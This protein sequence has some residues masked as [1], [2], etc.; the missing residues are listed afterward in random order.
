MMESPVATPREIALVS[1]RKLR[2]SKRNPRTHSKKQIRQIA[3]SIRRF[4]WT[5]PILTDENRMILAG[6]G[7]YEAARQLGLRE[8][9]VM[10]A[11]GLSDAEKRAL[12]LADNK[13]A[14]NAGWN[15]ALL[16]AEL[17]ELADLLPECDLDLEITGFEAA[18]IDVLMGDLVDPEHDPV[19]ELPD[20][21]KFPVSR[22]GDLWLLNNHRLRCGD[23]RQD[24]DIRTVLGRERAAMVFTDPPYNQK[25]SSIQGRGRIKHAE[26]I[27]AS[28]EMSTEQYTRF[29]VDALSLAAKHSL[30]GSIH[31]V[32]MDWRHAK[33]L[34]AAGEEIY[35]ELKNLVVWAKTNAGQG[36]FYRS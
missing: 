26:F 32:C 34:L 24:A 10:V 31:Y 30:T 5:Y 16:A 20:I 18:E 13:T 22:R 8:V 28:G 3:N 1:L 4:G 25:I 27:A 12:A 33:E 11:S 9:P 14:A 2:P 6:H 21:D 19:D 7:R 17:G 35:T 29:L 15:R 36:T 23:A